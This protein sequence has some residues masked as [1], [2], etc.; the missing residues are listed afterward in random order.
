MGGYDLASCKQEMVIPLVKTNS[1]AAANPH[2][3]MDGSEMVRDN[4]QMTEL[5]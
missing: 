4:E 5:V 2:H 1:W 3:H